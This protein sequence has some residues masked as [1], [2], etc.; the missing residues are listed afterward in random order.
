MTAENA[1]ENAIPCPVCGARTFYLNQSGSMTFFS[2]D[3]TGRPARVTPPGAAPALSA[4]TP[5]HC[6]HYSW[7]GT[8][9]G[10]LADLGPKE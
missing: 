9:A 4:D 6:A 1:L 8:L 10:L 2:L 5:I 3:S 7:S